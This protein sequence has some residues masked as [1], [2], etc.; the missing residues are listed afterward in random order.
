MSDPRIASVW[1]RLAGAV[2]RDLGP[3]TK[4]TLRNTDWFGEV[5]GV[6][7]PLQCRAT[8]RGDRGTDANLAVEYHGEGDHLVKGTRRRTIH[9]SGKA[10]TLSM[11]ALVKIVHE[12][13]AWHDR[14]EDA[15]KFEHEKYLELAA[16][17]ER[18]G[19]SGSEIN[20]NIRWTKDH[21]KV[22]LVLDLK[23][24]P[25]RFVSLIKLLKTHCYL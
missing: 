9:P 7:I 21:S 23:L 15:R 10:G 13:M 20:S 25:E 4:V 2:I 3:G 1:R 16:L 11:D 12:H 8:Y 5:N 17:V 24:E 22:S 19:L 18:A 14:K 6:F